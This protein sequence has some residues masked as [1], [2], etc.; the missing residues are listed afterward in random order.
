[1][2]LLEA[3]HDNSPLGIVVST[4]HE[5]ELAYRLTEI[6]L[7]RPPS[8]QWHRYQIIL[9]NRDD[10]IAEWWDDL[11]PSG[12]IQQFVIP[13]YWEH[14]VAEL[15]SIADDTRLGD[16]YWFKRSQEL[17]SESTMIPEFLE[18]YE[19]RWKIINNRSVFGYHGQKQRNG[20]T[21]LKR[22]HNG[23]SNS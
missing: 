19:E 18:Q 10:S 21:K 3:S 2:K 5:D 8:Y 1:M 7:V 9:V 22:N 20:Y 4:I 17:Q 16:S 14:T 15:R 23:N 12:S 11:G 13:S 6:N